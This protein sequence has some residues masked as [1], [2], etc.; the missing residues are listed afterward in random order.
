MIGT[1]T[2]RATTGHGEVY[3]ITASRSGAATT[4]RLYLDAS[5][6][7]SRLVLGLYSDVGGE[8]GALLAS[9]TVNTPAAGAWN[10]VALPAGIVAAGTNYWFALLNPT[11]STGTLAWR[12]RAGGSGGLERSSQSGTLAALPAT[13]AIGG[14]YTDGPVSG[15]AW[16]GGTPCRPRSP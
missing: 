16:A 10:T 15:S 14:R 9:G 7:A 1:S 3:R 4:L 5:S 6:T 11:G 2:S 8:A 12:D 13:W